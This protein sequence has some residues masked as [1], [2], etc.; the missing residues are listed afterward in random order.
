MNRL[1]LGAAIVLCTLLPV[2]KATDD[3]RLSSLL[4]ANA[5]RFPGKLAIYIKHLATGQEAS[6]DADHAMNSMSVIKLGIL[7]KAYQMAEKRELNLV[8]RVQLKRSDLI[9]GSGVLQFH[10]PGLNPTL[11]D[12]LIQMII[13]SDNAATDVMLERVGGLTSL[14]RWYVEHGFGEMRMQSTFSAYVAIIAPILTPLARGLSE[15]EINAAIVGQRMGELTPAGN[16]AA[17]ELGKMETWLGVCDKFKDPGTWLGSASARSIGR[18]LEQM[19]TAK[20]VSQASSDEMMGMLKSQQGGKRRIPMYLDTQY[21]IGNKTGD[22]PPCIANDVGVV[23]LRS[24][25]TV[26]VFLSDQIRGN[27]GEAEVRIGEI[28]RTVAEYFDGK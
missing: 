13:T 14:N 10:A 7:A 9:G 3:P 24:G 21:V 6:S 1:A 5:A 11:R 16:A 18:L 19:E 20:L 22:F 26:M 17:A 12:L 27:Y 25:P 15:A 4:S 28:A 8:E 2:A 23:Y